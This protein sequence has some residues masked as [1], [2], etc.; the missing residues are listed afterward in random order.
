VINQGKSMLLYRL[1]P[2]YRTIC[3]L[4][5]LC[6]RNGDRCSRPDILHLTCVVNISNA[7]NLELYTPTLLYSSDAK[8]NHHQCHYNLYSFFI[9]AL[10]VTTCTS[11]RPPQHNNIVIIILMMMMVVALVDFLLLFN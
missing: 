7:D 6:G 2:T 5:I 11:V 3:H 1:V 9:F 4:C 10:V 8:T